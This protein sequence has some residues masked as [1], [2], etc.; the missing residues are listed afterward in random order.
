M[1]TETTLAQQ[2]ADFAANLHYDDIPVAVVES[3]KARVL[4]ILGICAAA[5]PLETSRGA[6]AWAMEQGGSAQANAVGVAQALPASLAAFVNGVLAHSLDYDDT[7]LP[8]VLH[9]SA[10]V[11]PAV[12]AAAQAKGAN[13]TEVIR[14]IAIGL[15]TTVRLGMAGFDKESGNSV[16]FE[17]GQHATSICGTMGAATAVAAL[18]GDATLIRNSLGVAASMASGIIESNRTGGTVKRI[19][20]GWAA[21]SA[22]S[23]V[24]LVRF[25][26]TGPPTVLEG[27]FGFYQAWLHGKFKASEITDGLGKTWSIQDIFFK[28]YPANHFTHAAV[29]AAAALRRAGI[30]PELIESLVLGVPAPNLRTIGE[31]IEVKRR[32]E[33]GYMAQFSGPYAVAAGLLGG[34]GLEVGLDDYTDELAQDPVRRQIMAKVNVVPDAECTAIFPMQFPAVLTAHLVDG[35]TI[36]EKVLTTRGGPDRPLSFDELSRKFRD[37]A[38]RTLSSDAMDHLEAGCRDLDQ[39]ENVNDIF[40]HLS[41]I[42]ADAPTASIPS[43]HFTSATV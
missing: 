15:E 41:T 18:Y 14:A 29:D 4:D 21:H 37:N 42:D 20:C 31:P 6:R 34:G 5:A 27:R 22:I 43:T 28:P 25:G 12:L 36:V 23:A 39:S 26:L 30:T 1:S 19:H 13:G 40:V 35:R 8:S 38:Q 7:H 3:I 11:I 9:P 33:T 10:S 32:P 17:H 16:F 2:L 24:N